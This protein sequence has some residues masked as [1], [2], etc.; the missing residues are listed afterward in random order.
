M[1]SK[2]QTKKVN[3]Y[4]IKPSKY[5]DEGYVLRYFRGVLPSNTLACLAALTERVLEQGLLT[6]VD[7]RI[8]L[9]DETV[10][11]VD[12][13]KIC[14]SQRGNQKTIVCL[15]GVQTNQFPRAAD[16]AKTFRQAGLTVLIGGFHVS[17]HLAMLPNIPGDI[18]ELFDMGVSVV[19]GEVEESWSSILQDAVKGQLQSLYD[20]IDDKPDLYTAPVPLVHHGYLK[21]FVSSNFGT[22]DCG[23]GCPF[24]CSFCTIINVQ[25]R[26]MRFRSAETIAAAIREN[27][28]HK[29]INFYFFTDDNFAR[30][31]NWES[32]LEA[33]I[34]LREKEGIP[35][36]FMMQVD[37]LSYKIKNFVEKARRA[38]CSQVF[39][40]MESINT[41]NLKAAGKNQNSA[42][43]YRNLIEAYRTA[44]IATHVGY[45]LGLPFDTPD[46]IRCDLQRLMHEVQVDQASFFIFTPL[47]GSRDHLEFTQQ[48]IYMDPDFNKYDSFHETMLHPNFPKE[49]D[50]L[51]V[52]HEAWRT[53]YSFDNMRRVLHRASEQNYWNIF[54][55]FLW[56]KSSALI[57]KHHPMM[58][59]FFRC[60]GRT[61][62][63]PDV[64]PLP[65]LAYL[66][67]RIGEIRHLAGE[68]FKLL[69]EM[70]LLWLE[71]RKY[72][73]TERKIM[74][75]LR[76]LRHGIYGKV[77]LTELR[78]AYAR[79]RLGFPSLQ[80][81]S[82]FRLFV[83]RWNPFTLD[84]NFYLSED[85]L[86]F[87]QRT[88]ED[89][90]HGRLSKISPPLLF[91]RL[92]LDT[93]L[94]VHFTLD[95]MRCPAADSR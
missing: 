88:L 44:E 77:R 30:N 74:E 89:L 55:N 93:K 63:R 8:T 66:N 67:K 83:Q 58:A 1:N 49:G 84:G 15:V 7:I 79:A 72:T 37:V 25:G 91:R 50:L 82:G 33:L 42:E 62:L 80:I 3:L 10:S 95:W 24:N 38:G 52:Y 81:P 5:D 94:T 31:K 86:N 90:K 12:C 23:R 71:T 40:G 69:L 2:K 70:Q 53:F 22:V 92:W 78:L 73:E 29:K 68:S 36:Q 19:K 54:R 11:R 57:E 61:N 13:D 65:R 39:I 64:E 14:R 41:D 56:Y 35:V 60:K 16:L 75:E 48:N 87:W 9:I 17:G 4:L 27:Y 43:D 28:F 76:Q 34:D 46:S 26:K 45:I 6:A 18:Q 51:A 21:K 32:I 85:V 20:F 47:P 59:G